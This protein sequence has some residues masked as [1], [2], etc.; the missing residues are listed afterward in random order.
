MIPNNNMRIMGHMA[1][2]PMVPSPKT[3]DPP[4][5]ILMAILVMIG[6]AKVTTTGPVATAPESNAMG[7]ISP[8]DIY[9]KNS[10]RIYPGIKINA[11]GIS[12]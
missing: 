4:P 11:I 12:K 7:M 10:N 5:S 2:T 1:I 8:G 9:V 6:R 3:P